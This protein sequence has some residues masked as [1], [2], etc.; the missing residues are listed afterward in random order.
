VD[1]DQLIAGYRRSKVLGA[2]LHRRR[3][4][5]KGRRRP[6]ARRA[7]ALGTRR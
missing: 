1:L 4:K 5:G 2:G 7:F 3:M 6:N